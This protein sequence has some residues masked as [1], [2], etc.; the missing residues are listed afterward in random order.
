MILEDYKI[1]VRIKL[2]AL[3]TS[4]MFL[5]L[6]G[7]YFELYV[8]HKVE[9]LISGSN[10][11]NSPFKLMLATFILS[12]PALMVFL[13]LV[14]KPGLARWLNIGVGVFFTLFTFLVGLASLSEWRAFYVYLAFLESFLTAALAWIAW[15]WP[16]SRV[17][18]D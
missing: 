9:G 5:Y 3:W 13:S 15:T 7:D 16:K 11:L 14:L 4:V 12:V 6:Y 18:N 2:A 10:M 17:Y 1:N 8:P